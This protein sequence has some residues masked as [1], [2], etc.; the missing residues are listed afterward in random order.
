[1]VD[2]IHFSTLSTDLEDGVLNG[3]K[4]GGLMNWYAE[5]GH[6]YLGNTPDIDYDQLPP[7]YY[8][9]TLTVF[10]N[11]GL[12]SSDSITL[13]VL[14]D[15]DGDGLPDVYEN[16]HPC[17]HAWDPTDASLDSDHDGLSNMDEYRLG[18]DPCSADSDGDGYTDGTE[19][20]NGS[21]PL[22][23]GNIPQPPIAVVGPANITITLPFTGGL[24]APELIGISNNGGG[25]LAWNIV[26]DV[27][28]LSYGPAADSH[29]GDVVTVTLN[30]RGVPD[31]STGHLIFYSNGTAGTSKLPVE[32]YINNPSTKI[33]LPVIL[34]N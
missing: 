5:P 14:A 29:A 2:S 4:G 7:G 1:Q 17:L 27:P 6:I 13:T 26:S 34:K 28:W 18:T 32:V 15:F 16:A 31:G 30:T 25:T 9:V 8:T 24:P 20:N 19:F 22:N 12:S 3:Q 21:D 23:A 11:L 33:Y 10:D